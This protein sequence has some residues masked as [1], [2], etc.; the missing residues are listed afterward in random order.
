MKMEMGS[1]FEGILVRLGAWGKTT[2]LQEAMGRWTHDAFF[3]RSYNYG[4]SRVWSAGQI[5]RYINRESE[6]EREIRFAIRTRDSDKLIGECSIEPQ[7]NHH[8]GWVAIGIGEADYRGKGYGT[9]AMR[10]LVSYG[11]RE[12]GLHRIGLGVFGNNIGAIRSYEKSGFRQEVVMREALYRDGVRQNE[13]TMG[14][15]RREWEA[16]YPTW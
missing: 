16:L 7:W 10:L 15:L 2:E 12:L 3:T 14:I 8:S 4:I 1:L 6:N 9:D 11:F 13:I 5:E